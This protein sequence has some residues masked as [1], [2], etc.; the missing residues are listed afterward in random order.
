MIQEWQAR[1][2]VATIG[3]GRSPDRRPLR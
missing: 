2:R 1:P 3:V